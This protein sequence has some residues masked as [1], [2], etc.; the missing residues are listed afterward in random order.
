[1]LCAPDEEAA[2]WGGIADA[3]QPPPAAAAAADGEAK[4]A[5]G[6]SGS[7]SDSEEEDEGAHLGAV[8]VWPVLDADGQPLAAGST[9][10]AERQQLLQQGHAAMLSR[11]AC[12]LL[13]GAV[14]RRLAAYAGSLQA[15]LE[16]LAELEAQEQGGAAA[17][18]VAAADEADAR[19]AHSAA[20]LL[21]V[22]EKEVLQG[23]LTALERRL[24]AL[25]PAQPEGGGK[26]KRKALAP[27][28]KQAKQQA[29]QAK[30]G[31]G[32]RKARHK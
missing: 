16:Q 27:A 8:Q 32:G 26:A 11:G 5:A 13:Q 21:R 14:Q 9:A 30:Q 19:V 7:G 20:L 22:T 29:K 24:A 1:M 28:G 4:A 23:L 6:G 3:L 31:S 15:D 18:A 25:P 17:A 2:A 12:E 10:A